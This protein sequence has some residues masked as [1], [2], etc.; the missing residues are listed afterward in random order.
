MASDYSAN[1]HY[2]WGVFYKGGAIP[3]VATL[4]R[5]DAEAVLESLDFD[6]AEVRPL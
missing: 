5:G 4:T 2:E 3:W 6:M 1:G